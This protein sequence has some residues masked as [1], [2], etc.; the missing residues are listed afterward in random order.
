MSLITEIDILNES[1]N[2]FLTYA[3][4]V[5]TD[6]AIPSI[7]D[8][9][10]SAQRKIL[11][12][13]EEFLKMNSKSK[14]KKCNAIVGSTLMTSYFHGDASC[15]GVLCKMSQPYLMRYPLIIGQ[16]SLGTQENNDMRA[17]SRY[18]LTGDTL[19]PSDKGTIKI[20]EIIKNSSESEEYDIDLN[21]IGFDGKS[22]HASKLFNSGKYPVLKITLQ[23]GMSIRVTENHPLMVLN[24]DLTFGWKLA[25]ELKEEDKILLL[26]P[27]EVP[28][29]GEGDDYLEAAMLGSMI[30]EGY[31]TTQSRIGINNKDLA[32][33]EPVVQ[34]MKRE[35]PSCE[36]SICK[37]EKRD[38]YEFCFADQS[39]QP[40]FIKKFNFG[41]SKDK[42]LPEQYFKGDLKYKATLLK[43]LFEGDGSIHERHGIIYSSISET[44]INQIQ[45]SLLQDFGI[46]STINRSKTR[47]EIKL[48][49]NSI[50]SETFKNKINFLSERKKESLEDF[51][52]KY[53][54]KK[55]IS[56]INICNI[57]EITNYIRE[58]Y[59]GNF[60]KKNGFS[61]KKSYKKAKG[62]ISE[63]EFN[64]IENLIENYVYLKIEKIEPVEDMQIVYSLKIDDE[65][66]AY[67][68]NGFINHNTEAK[69][70]KYA[71][72]MMNNFKKNVVPLKETY[73][74][75]YMEPIVLPSLFPNAICNGR[76]AIGV[77]MSH[78][79][80][81]HSLKEAC[82]AIIFYIK[83]NGIT[84][85]KLLEIMPGPDFPLSNTIIN[86]K[87][88]KEAFRTG[89]SST[90]LKI[91]GDYEIKDN[92]IIFTSIPYRAYRNKIK[93]QIE[94]NIDQLE[95]Y[96][97]DFDD[98]SVLGNNRLVFTLK[99]GA[100]ANK[101]LNKLFVLTDLQNSV[102]YNMNF[103]VNGTPKM[104]SMIDMIKYYVEHQEQVLLES[105]KF[106]LRKAKSRKEIVEGL[107]KALEDIDN[108]IKLIKSSESSKN[109][110]EKLCEKYS[111]TENQA[112]A[113]VGMKLG[114]LAKLESVELNKELKSLI[115]AITDHKR[116][117]QEKEYRNLKLIEKIAWLKDNYG[118][119]RRTKLEQIEVPKEEK[120]I[121]EI[122][123]E[124]CVVLITESGLIKRIPSKSFKAQKRNGKGVKSQ[125]DI[126]SKV[127]RTNTIDN[128]MIFTTK[129][130]MYK[131]LVENIPEGTN[132]SQ[133]VS[134]SSL[135]ELEYDE[136]VST[137]YSLYHD[138]KE[139]YICIA[140]KRGMIKKTELAEFNKTKKKT[141][142]SAIKL[143]ENDEVCNVFLMTDEDIIVSTRKGYT[144]HF[145]SGEVRV[146]GKTAQGVKSIKLEEDDEIVSVLPIRNKEDYYAVFYKNGNAR[147]SKLSEYPTQG[148]GGKGV[149]NA[150]DAEIAAAALV[151]N[152]DKILVC[153]NMSNICINA[154]DISEQYR[155]ALG[156]KILNTGFIVE[157]SKI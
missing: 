77:S 92:K 16:G 117:I 22:H 15:Y 12:T 131:I 11:W 51:V 61:N 93:E 44:L 28:F 120:E 8:G 137:I 136:K 34:Y 54:Q 72:L 7:E 110:K 9:L 33:I 151:D 86:K 94:K 85:D 144:I 26:T 55:I 67:I 135:I 145:V 5:L 126:T 49:V 47:N 75:E 41:K 88:I 143:K 80:L 27:K 32:M 48:I 127:I 43:Y 35:V 118:D 101:V 45:I 138:T 23:N 19:I 50:Y 52:E 113:I 62:K 115:D 130:K 2:N 6:R 60:Y 65:S 108:I 96:I 20:E 123:P 152:N 78:N 64:K 57:Y 90:S 132:R 114:S 66:H 106:D 121:V 97:E 82:E 69:P 129:G 146:V 104:C 76:Q 40:L 124:E 46:I 116:I 14:T 13:M 74:G 10:L 25:E 37:N 153:G 91:R 139:K 102:S 17:S 107:V 38:Y 87:D 149:R 154:S 71:D 141:G 156:V 21:V 148:R 31:V 147:K 95:R 109:A 100:D 128:L 125:D 53:N 70:S 83:N 36:A 111:F 24:K 105:T 4:E 68:G 89:H 39:Y 119:E 155:T 142:I 56:N 140:T 112:K 63:E 157:I 150:K 3:S 30:S 84:L 59:K 29:N 18:C 134:I 79:S 103:I 42:C 122:E 73:N 81:P 133:G 98:E 99:K 58:N 1:K